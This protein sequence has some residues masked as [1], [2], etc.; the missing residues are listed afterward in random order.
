MPSASNPSPKASR[1]IPGDGNG[2]PPGANKN[3]EDFQ[4]Q[5]SQV[6]KTVQESQKA[7]CTW[8]LETVFTDI[9]HEEGQLYRICQV[10]K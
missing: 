1:D 6:A 4:H 10:C 2:D 3:A 8:D 9:V 7:C 5:D